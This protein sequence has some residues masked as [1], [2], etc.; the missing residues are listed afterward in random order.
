MIGAAAGQ[1]STTSPGRYRADGG[2]ELASCAGADGAKRQLAVDKADHGFAPA[3]RDAGGIADRQGIEKFVRDQVKRVR[4][5]E[6]S[7]RSSQVTG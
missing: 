1:S 2:Q 5:A 7:M 6:S 4:R 3:I